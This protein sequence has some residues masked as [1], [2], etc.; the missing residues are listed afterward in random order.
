MKLLKNI[1]LVVLLCA[2]VFLR[3]QLNVSAYVKHVDPSSTTTVGSISLTP[4]GGSTP[5]TYSWSPGSYTTQN[6][7]GVAR[8]TYTARVTDNASTTVTHPY[9]VG[10]R[11][12]WT[13]PYGIIFRNDSLIYDYSVTNYET[14]FNCIISKNTLLASTDGWAEVVLSSTSDFYLFGFMDSSSVAPGLY[15]DIDYGFHIDPYSGLLKAWITGS[16]VSIGG[17]SVGDAI[18]IERSSSTFKLSQNGTVV[19]TLTVPT[20][21]PWKLKAS[22]SGPAIRNVGASFIDTSGV[23]FPNYVQNTLLM[24]HASEPAAT[25]GTLSLSPNSGYSFTWNPGSVTAYSVSGAEGTYSVTAKD[26]I[27]NSSS[28]NFD[29]LY[30]TQYQDLEGIIFRNDSLI[31]H[32]PYPGTGWCTAMNKNSLEV[33]QDGEIT[34]VGPSSLQYLVTGFLDTPSGSPGDYYDIDEGLFEQNW[35]IYYWSA[36]YYTLLGNRLP[37]DVMKIKRVG[38]SVNFYRN[39]VL[40]YTSTPTNTNVPW[41]IKTALTAGYNV[42]NIGTSVLPTYKTG[43]TNPYGIIFRNDSLIYDY[44]VT[45]YETIFNCIISKNTLKA[46]VDGYAE[47]PINS[48][49]DYYLFGFIDSSSVAPGLYNDIDYGFHIDKWSGLLKS[50]I[51]GSLTTIGGYSTGD[52]IRIAREGTTFKIEQNGTTVYTL[53]VPTSKP[54]KLKASISGAPLRNIEATFVDSTGIDFPNYVQNTALYRHSTGVNIYD[55]S[56]S[57][58]PNSGYSYTWSPVSST[59]SSITSLN[60]GTYSVTI[61]DPQ[62]NTSTYYYKLYN[63]I[64]Y[65]NLEGITFRND[66]LITSLPYPGTGWC[67]ATSTDVLKPGE[68]GGVSWVAPNTLYYLVTG[69]LDTPSGSP[70]DYYDI[71]EGLF[72]QNWA[73]YYWSA[74][75]YTLLGN[76]LPGD[77]MRIERSGGN[78]NFYRNNVLLYTSVP[79][80][81]NVNWKIKTALTGGYNVANIGWNYPSSDIAVTETHTNCSG[82]SSSD[83]AITLSVTAGDPSYTYKWSNTATTSA[84]SSLSAG[85]YSA[86]IADTYGKKV[87]ISIIITTCN[88]TANA[89]TSPIYFNIGDSYTLTGSGSGGTTPYSYSWTPNSYVTP[90]VNG[91]LSNTMVVSPP[92]PITYSLT[93]KDAY[94]CVAGNTVNLIPFPYA[95]LR[96]VPDGGYY[97]L[98]QNK[99]LFKYDGQ[100]AATT[101]TCNVYNSSNAVVITTGLAVNSGDNRYALSAASLSTG[102]YM[103]EMINEKKEKLYLRF[104]KP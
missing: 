69:Y 9:N 27:N 86:L 16:L 78:V 71:D 93:I 22:I 1:L 89:G 7:T 58:S 77:L 17:Y 4:A 75:Y 95:L 49:S 46:G 30:K 47:L 65:S 11:T 62:D 70:G 10:Y 53:T 72:E 26:P 32:T 81:T 18:K 56:I 43:W 68:D 92:G 15:T 25:D 90:T 102:Y 85:T 28:N 24:R 42:A 31:T 87:G 74:G 94:S 23:D 21:R 55:G 50:W 44:S 8:G 13:N 3:G 96:S 61:K 79:T 6:L 54:W 20:S 33:G 103:L 34:W 35:A 80:N 12:F 51:L 2:T 66:S 29:L 101:L 38:G 99:M 37:G 57:L 64:D 84:I 41:K 52:I 91:N 14:I 73:I 104:Y 45:N 5:Y 67:T 83:G 60:A 48:T 19:Y 59:S 39:N 36:G 97:K 98:N 63:K 76:R 88:V 82:S 100:Y 40:L